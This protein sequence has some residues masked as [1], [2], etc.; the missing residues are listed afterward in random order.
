MNSQQHLEVKQ[1]WIPKKERIWVFGAMA[2]STIYLIWQL[3]N[4]FHLPSTTLH[5]RLFERT[6]KD[7]GSNA[8]IALF[9]VVSNYVLAFIIKQGILGK[10]AHLKKGLVVLLRIVKKYHV[11]IAILAIALIIL[12]TVAV[13]MFGFKWDFNNISGLLALIVLLPVPISGLLRYKRL[14]KKWHLRCGLA[15]AV[16]FLIHAFL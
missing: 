10:F 9:I 6:F 8:R 1:P 14:D 7:Y 16:L 3:W 11:T 12:H 5:S 15:F 2:V 13:F 4:L